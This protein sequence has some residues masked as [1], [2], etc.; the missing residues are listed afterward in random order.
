MK[1]RLLSLLCC[2]WLSFA[3]GIV[4]TV[5]TVKLKMQTEYILHAL[6]SIYAQQFLSTEAPERECKTAVCRWHSDY[7]W[8]RLNES[9]DPCEDFYAHVCSS[10]WFREEKRIDGQ[11]YADFSVAQLLEDVRYSLTRQRRPFTEQGS[12]SFPAQAVRMQ[13]LCD[14]AGSSSSVGWD[15]LRD[16][17]ARVGLGGWPYTD[18]PPAKWSLLRV[19]AG[20]ERDVGEGTLAS[21]TLRRDLSQTEGYQ[22]HVEPPE[23]LLR[24][25]L[26]HRRSSGSLVDYEAQLASLLLAALGNVSV[27][28]SSRGDSLASRLAADL[29]AL[30]KRLEAIRGAPLVPLEQRY[31]RAGQLGAVAKWNWTAFIMETLRG[32]QS[33]AANTTIVCDRCTFFR[34]LML[35]V[36]ETPQRTV[37][38]YAGV[39]LLAL[40]SPLLPAHMPWS[41]FLMQLSSRGLSGLP[42]RVE[43]CLGLLERTYRYGS[44][45]LARM[46]L[47]R[48]FFTVYR[49]Q[50]DRQLVALASALAHAA[51]QGAARLA[52][53][54]P[55]ERRVAQSK[56]AGMTVQV[57]AEPLASAMSLLRHTRHAYLSSQAPNLDLDAQYPV[58]VFGVPS[59]YYFPLRNHLFL[60]QSLVSF[61][62]HVSNTLDASFVPVVGRP[63]LTE[64]LRALDSLDGRAVDSALSLRAWWDKN[65]SA[66]FELLQQCLLNQYKALY[67]TS[68]PSDANW[69]EHVDVQALFREVASVTPLLDVFQERQ[70]SAAKLLI[71]VGRKRVLEPVQLFFV[72]FALSLCDHHGRGKLGH[73]QA[74]LGIMPGTVRVNLALANSNEFAHA[75]GCE[76][77]RTMS[78]ATRCIVW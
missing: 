21:V 54:R 41:A 65:S 25:F 26:L 36:Q 70:K 59:S 48:Q 75:F 6:E 39:R 34:K 33:V 63:I 52:F 66:E 58:R 42:E 2:V 38:N 76:P 46:A 71:R 27:P 67:W 8:G 7:L 62:A 51:T 30:E 56:V 43:A 47:G 32:A 74:K 9:V 73:L 29:V 13:S 16:A 12:W 4:C 44:A 53:L 22:V 19:L 35:L 57:S 24:H 14:H 40:L 11:P 78:P 64:L 17:L 77:N 69:R 72:N 50:Y 28:A 10:A 23:T 20:L 55:D 49:S 3:L 18:E 45:M 68:G 31:A 5:F 61:L 37:A 15:E 60:P 1:R